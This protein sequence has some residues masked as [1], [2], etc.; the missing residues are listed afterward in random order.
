MRPVDRKYRHSFSVLAARLQEVPP[1][2]ANLTPKEQELLDNAYANMQGA[3]TALNAAVRSLPQFEA[4]TDAN[5]RLGAACD[6][7]LTLS[8]ISTEGAELTLDAKGK[9]QIEVPGAPPAV[10]TFRPEVVSDPPADPDMT[11]V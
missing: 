2:I 7:I 1:L 4:V 9:P 10:D 11:A 5:A 6:V 3:Q 8:G